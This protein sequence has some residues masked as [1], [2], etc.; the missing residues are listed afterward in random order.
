M[1]LDSLWC[2]F[3]AVFVIT[4]C[5][6]C[7]QSLLFLIFGSM[8]LYCYQIYRW[9]DCIVTNTVLLTIFLDCFKTSIKRCI[10]LP[11]HCNT[12]EGIFLSK[13]PISYPLLGILHFLMT[14]TLKNKNFIFVI[15]W[16]IIHFLF[17]WIFSFIMKLLL[18]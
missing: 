1:I 14:H 6:Q 5:I 17:L 15:E 10:P 13:K 18:K 4:L 7:E 8:K 12:N 11:L 2:D 3:F 9:C 16:V